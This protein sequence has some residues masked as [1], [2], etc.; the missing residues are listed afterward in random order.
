MEIP[1]PHKTHFSSCTPLLQLNSKQSVVQDFSICFQ[2]TA[3]QISALFLRRR[4][5]LDTLCVTLC[6]LLT[7]CNSKTRKG[8]SFSVH[9][10]LYTA[11]VTRSVVLWLHKTHFSQYM[12]HVQ[13]NDSQKLASENRPCNADSSRRSSLKKYD[14]QFTSTSFNTFRSAFSTLWTLRIRRLCNWNQSEGGN[15]MHMHCLDQKEMKTWPWEWGLRGSRTRKGFLKNWH[16]AN[17]KPWQDT[18]V[19][20]YYIKIINFNQVTDAV[21]EAVQESSERHEVWIMQE[22]QSVQIRYEGRIW[23][24]EGVWHTWLSAGRRDK[25]TKSVVV[26]LMIWYYCVADLTSCLN[27]LIDAG[28]CLRSWYSADPH[29]DGMRHRPKWYAEWYIWS[30]TD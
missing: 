7:Y 17:S 15:P 2:P 24:N 21:S 16:A 6:Y 28:K 13:F 26:I 4:D 8:E 25:H 5:I 20:R 1:S 23:E 22:I 18:L 19:T 12:G 11:H 9:I 30:D 27:W 3:V 14:E 29:H 10:R